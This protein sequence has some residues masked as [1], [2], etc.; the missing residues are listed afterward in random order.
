MEALQH[1]GIREIAGSFR[2]YPNP[3]KGVVNFESNLG[4]AESELRIFNSSGQVVEIARI[5]K[6]S[7]QLD[8]S[9]LPKGLYY[10]NHSKNAK[11]VLHKLILQ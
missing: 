11:V 5:N 4:N 1:S 7:S 9:H 2:F 6:G 8:L 3:S 10:L